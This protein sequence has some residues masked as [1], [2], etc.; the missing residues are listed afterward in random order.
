MVIREKEGGPGYIVEKLAGKKIH[1]CVSDLRP[2]GCAFPNSVSFFFFFFDCRVAPSSAL[3]WLINTV[4]K[5]QRNQGP[6][7]LNFW[8]EF[9]KIGQRVLY[10][11]LIEIRWVIFCFFFF[12]FS[13]LK[14]LLPWNWKCLQSPSVEAFLTCFFVCVCFLPLEN[15]NL[16]QN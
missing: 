5:W 9:W 2:V 13:F 15:C 12:Y 4:S 1:Q 16:F 3:T 6:K 8:I 14:L 10:R 7:F 11:P